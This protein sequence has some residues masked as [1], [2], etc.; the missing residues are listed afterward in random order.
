MI[1]ADGNKLGDFPANSCKIEPPANLRRVIGQTL[2]NARGFM[3]LQRT[4]AAATL[5]LLAAICRAE[6]SPPGPFDLDEALARQSARD[7]ISGVATAYDCNVAEH[8]FRKLG[9]DAKPVYLVEVAM[10]GPDCEDALLL[11]ARHGSTRDFLFRAWEP[12]PDI[13]TI[14]PI[15]QDSGI[16]E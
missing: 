7:L 6:E 9:T 14:D 10:D 16:L 2:Y 12:A 3:M 8:S 11:L 15:E 4:I 13:E 1:D 5:L